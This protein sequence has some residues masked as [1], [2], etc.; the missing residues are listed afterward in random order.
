MPA[1][2]TSGTSGLMRAGPADTVAAN[3]DSDDRAH[4]A[5]PADRARLDPPPFLPAPDGDR[6]RHRHH[7]DQR[8]G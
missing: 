1:V 6:R 3:N 7:A 4:E 2:A 5:A 8:I